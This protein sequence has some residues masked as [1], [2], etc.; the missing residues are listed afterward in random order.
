MNVPGHLIHLINP[1][2]LVHMPGQPTYFFKSSFLL[3]LSSSL[4]QKLRPQDLH[5]LLTVKCS[6]YISI[7]ARGK[8]ALFA[9][10]TSLMVT[11]IMRMLTV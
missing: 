11:S 4:Y 7:E 10:R 1:T 9:S 3:S 8:C 2:M 5:E 6:E